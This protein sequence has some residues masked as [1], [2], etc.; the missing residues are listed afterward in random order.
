MLGYQGG[1][2]LRQ[3]LTAG[4]VFGFPARAV[5]FRAIGWKSRGE[6]CDKTKQSRSELSTSTDNVRDDANNASALRTALPTE[7]RR[8]SGISLLGRNIDLLAVMILINIEALLHQPQKQSRPSAVADERL[9]AVR[10]CGGMR[11]EAEPSVHA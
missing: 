9:V 4:R 7:V 8:G 6:N 2:C 5:R 11:P 3:M 10:F 1:T